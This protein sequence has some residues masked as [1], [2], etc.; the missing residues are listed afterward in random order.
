MYKSYFHL[1]HYPFHNTPDPEFFFNSL[2]HRE[3]LATMAYGVQ[4]GKGFVLIIGDVGTGKTML[5]KVINK[6]IPRW[7]VFSMIKVAYSNIN[8]VMPIY[9]IYYKLIISEMF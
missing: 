2:S 9:K 8:S 1:S 6:P 4:E 3:A 5:S 7:P